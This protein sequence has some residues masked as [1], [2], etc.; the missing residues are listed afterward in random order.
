MAAL[1]KQIKSTKDRQELAKITAR[2]NEIESAK[3]ELDFEVYKAIDPE[4][5]VMSGLTSQF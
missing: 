3:K 4:Y 1:N 2:Y 5:T